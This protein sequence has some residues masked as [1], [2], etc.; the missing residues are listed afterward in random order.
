MQFL[1]YVDLYLGYV[2]C[3]VPTEI[4]NENFPPLDGS[5]CVQH[6]VQV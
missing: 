5:Q 3:L 4:W 6:N 1:L 2:S